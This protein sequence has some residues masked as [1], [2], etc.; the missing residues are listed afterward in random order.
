LMHQ[1]LR[2]YTGMDIHVHDWLLGLQTS[3]K[4]HIVN[5]IPLLALIV[6][7]YRFPEAKLFYQ[8]YHKAM[9]LLNSPLFDNVS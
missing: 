4:S 2:R 5:R 1:Q 8:L 6:L 3:L 7:H 9:K